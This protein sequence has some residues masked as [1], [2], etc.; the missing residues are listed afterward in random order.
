MRRDGVVE[1]P[2]WVDEWYHAKNAEKGHK[3][4]SKKKLQEK[5][6]IED[7]SVDAPTIL[8]PVPSVVFPVTGWFKQNISKRGKAAEQT[9]GYPYSMALLSDAAKKT[10]KNMPAILAQLGPV[11]TVPVSLDKPEPPSSN[12]SSRPEPKKK[13]DKRG[14][15]RVEKE[16]NPEEEEEEDDEEEEKQ[17]QPQRKQHKKEERA[18]TFADAKKP[19]PSVQPKQ[20][21]PAPAKAPTL[22]QK[23][24]EQS[25]VVREAMQTFFNAAS[26]GM[27]TPGTFYYERLCQEG[28]TFDAFFGQGGP[29]DC[30]FPIA[31]IILKRLK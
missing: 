6:R 17:T 3:E 22:N 24:Q 11:G 26:A 1:L 28:M 2:Y 12:Q 29:G 15:K 30:V 5:S 10:L 13:E 9:G 25:D 8:A 4:K 27:A 21:P 19:P 16:K 31:Q 18:V 14:K 23:P 20:Q 7:M